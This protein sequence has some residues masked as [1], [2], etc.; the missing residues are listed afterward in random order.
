M[1]KKHFTKTASLLL[2]L[3]VTF[4]ATACDSFFV[5]DSLKDLKQIVAEVDISTTLANE[6]AYADY[7]D[8]VAG[9]IRDKALTATVSKRDLVASFLSVG[10][11]WMQ[12][13]LSA[14]QVFTSLMTQLTNSKILTQY[15]TAYY[16]KKADTI[17]GE[18]TLVK[19]TEEELADATEKEKALLEEYPEVLTMKYF[20]TDYGKTDDAEVMKAYYETVYALKSNLN[21]TIDS[22][23]STLI[24]ADDTATESEDVRTM[25]TKVKQQKEDYLPML[26]GALNYDVYTGRNGVTECGEYEKQAGSTTTTRK[27]A[28]NAFLSSLRSYGL[29]KEGENVANVNELDYYYLELSSALSSALVEKYYEDL[30]DKAIGNL[31]A[32]MVAGKYSELL[33]GQTDLYANDYAAFEKALEDVAEDSYLLYGL[34]NYGFVY[35]ILIPFSAEQNQAYKAVQNKGLTLNAQYQARKSL[36]SNIVAEDLRGTWLSEDDAAHHAYEVTAEGTT[37]FYGATLGTKAQLFFEDNAKETEKYEKLTHYAGLY[38]YQGTW[39]DGKATPKKDMKIDAFIA[40]MEGYINFTLGKTAA[41]K[42]TDESVWKSNY[43]TASYTDDKGKVKNYGDFIYYAGKVNMQ[44]NPADY[45]NPASD[46]YKALSAVN[47]LMFAYSTD[48][49]C[50]NSYMGYAVSAYKTSFVNEFE[51]ASQ[52]VVQQGVGTYAVVPSDYGWH[53]IY[54]SYKF[55]G[56]SVYGDTIDFSNAETNMNDENGAFYN[57]FYES[58][59]ATSAANHANAIQSA[60][61]NQYKGSVTLYK[62]KYQDLLDL[63]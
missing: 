37:D 5:T 31:S 24:K 50:L 23:E 3:G 53:I 27:K 6:T 57:L 13:G 47:E 29:I 58:L 30:Q 2:A 10:Y 39:E 63:Q 34:P 1:N 15:A 28:Y 17:D 26:N 9:L 54:C 35:N 33:Q 21:A 43:D 40:E 55:E 22:N 62:E 44:A 42:I 8:D 36:L 45:F 56:G 18:K 11:S 59:K 38:P 46:S 16:L 41:A 61:L 14:E 4:G 20:L 7:A 25:P 19:F 48:P 52:W 32:D 60:V 51:Y 12:Q 49:G